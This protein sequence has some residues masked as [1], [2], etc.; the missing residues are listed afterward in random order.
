MKSSEVRAIITDA[1]GKGMKQDKLTDLLVALAEKAGI[2]E[3][4]EPAE[5]VKK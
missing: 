5:K 4:D 1:L 3:K 2:A